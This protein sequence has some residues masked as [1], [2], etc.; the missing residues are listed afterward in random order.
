MCD[1]DVGGAGWGA[2][3]TTDA[4]D[5]TQ[6]KGKSLALH[7]SYCGQKAKGCPI[8]KTVWALELSAHS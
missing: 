2:S 6:L 4:P 1:V 3:W 8:V 5:T 7:I